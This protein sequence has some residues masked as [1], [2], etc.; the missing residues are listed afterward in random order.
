MGKQVVA[1]HLKCENILI[2]ML[3]IKKEDCVCDIS[4]ISNMRD[5]YKTPCTRFRANENVKLF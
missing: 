1:Q 4:A 3:R 2:R 5:S